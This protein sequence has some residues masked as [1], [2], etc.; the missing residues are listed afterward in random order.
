MPPSSAS[1]SSVSSS[2]TLGL[3]A[4]PTSP[5]QEPSSI[6]S[7]IGGSSAGEPPGPGQAAHPSRMAAALRGGTE[8][9]RQVTEGEQGRPARRV[10][11]SLPLSLGEI[12]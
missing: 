7:S 5:G 10:K 4:A 8:S 6:S 9:S 11:L 12:T 2:S 3:R 1:W